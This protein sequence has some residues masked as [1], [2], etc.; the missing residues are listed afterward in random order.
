[1]GRSVF[2]INPN[3]TQEVTDQISLALEQYR[4]AGG[5]E[6]V[7]ETLRSG[8][9][10][11]ESQAH[12]DGSTERLLAY[13]EAHPQYAQADAVVLA[14]FSDPGFHAMRETLTCPVYGSAECAYLTAASMGS[15]F[16]VISILSRAICAPQAA[17]APDGTGT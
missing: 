5:P 9:P 17:G 15:R 11:I 2:V 14:C 8:P 6:I 12:V 3:S 10:G 7:C 4:V 16:G 13:F 1:M